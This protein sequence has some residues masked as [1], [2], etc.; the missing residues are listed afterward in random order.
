MNKAV[1][2]DRDGIIN[3]K[4]LPHD[5]VKKWSEFKF[6]PRIEKL[7]KRAN[8]KGL[9]VIVVTNQRGIARGLMTKKNVEEIHRKMKE[10]LKRKGAKIDAIYYCPHNVKDNC[11]CRKPKPGMLLQAA[12]DFNISL[13]ESVIIG[14]DETDIGTGK[15]AG[16]KTIL[17]RNNQEYQ[18]VKF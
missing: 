10:V 9:L 6:I 11:R 15:E 3:K 16:C 8:K 12:K 4:P 17:I 18:S 5:Y 1:F 2:L 7:I 14:D 13:K